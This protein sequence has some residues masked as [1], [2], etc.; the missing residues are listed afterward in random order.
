MLLLLVFIVVGAVHGTALAAGPEDGAID[1]VRTDFNA[2]FNA[3]SAEQIGKLLDDGA[4]W[5]P[6][7]KQM[8]TGREKIMAHYA[9][10]FARVKATIE[11]KPGEIMADRELAVI[12]GDFSRSDTPRKGGAPKK[13]K[14]HYL[15]TLKK[16]ADNS[17]KIVRDIW[18]EMSDAP[19]GKR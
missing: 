3:G 1:R 8:L 7:G 19:T 11:L 2:A 4:I 6:F 17:W 16:Q 14:G 15:L 18:N 5:L 13:V 12:S 10:Y 9:A